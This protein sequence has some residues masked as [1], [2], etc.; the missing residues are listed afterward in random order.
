MWNPKDIHDP[1][2]REKVLAHLKAA[3]R[4][5]LR[6]KAARDKAGLASFVALLRSLKLSSL[7]QIDNLK[8]LREVV[9]ALEA[10]ASHNR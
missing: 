1:A 4:G 6:A 9:V 3:E 10:T 7:D 8:T 2:I 5:L